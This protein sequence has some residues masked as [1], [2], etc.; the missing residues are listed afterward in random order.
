MMANPRPVT[1]RGDVRC[2]IQTFLA[3]EADAC[4]TALY[5][6]AVQESTCTEGKKIGSIE[7][8]F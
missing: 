7:T 2:N 5:G 3:G 4:G 6:E 8:S 1:S